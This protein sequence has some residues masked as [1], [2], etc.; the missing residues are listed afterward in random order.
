LD[1][2]ATNEV[3]YRSTS[4]PITVGHV[5]HAFKNGGIETGILN[6]VNYGNRK[7]FRHV[8]ICLTEAGA[9]AKRLES[10]TCTVIELRKQAGNDFSLPGRI[11]AVAREHRIDILHA[12]GWPA[13]VE[14]AIAA[15]LAGVRAAI[16]GFHGRGIG[17]LQGLTRRRRWAQRI[18][19][20][21]YDRVITLNSHMQSE[22]ANECRISPELI[23][24]VWNGVDVQKFR[25]LKN[26]DHLRQKLGLPANRFIIGNVARLDPVKNHQLIF[27]SLAVVKANGFCPLLLLVGDGPHRAALERQIRSLGLNSD[28]LLFGYSDLIP[29]ILNCFD[30]YVQSSF[31]EGFSNTVLEAM[32][33]GLPVLATDVGGTSDVLTDGREGYL[34]KS[35]D[36]TELASLIIRLAK[37]QEHRYS[38]AQRARSRAVDSFPVEAMVDQYQNIYSGLLKDF[39]NRLDVLGHA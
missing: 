29:E 2:L 34:L 17:D 26:Q 33:C 18:V 32:A 24:V 10:R 14:T 11:S 1:Q 23:R 28:V 25:P 27:K 7:R 31:Y 21:W 6:I 35:D 9:F 39:R 37:D 22:L 19:I 3:Q 16:Y 36:H 15:R 20:R 4:V 38:L 30:L 8:I 5:V 13:M 12:R